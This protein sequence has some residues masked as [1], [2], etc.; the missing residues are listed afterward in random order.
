MARFVFVTV[1]PDGAGDD[2][3]AEGKGET[4]Y[5]NADAVKYVKP[6]SA[7]VST[8]V[9][10]DGVHAVNV[11]GTVH[12]VADRLGVTDRDGETGDA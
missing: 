4:R 9:F 7:N 8:L 1:I 12:E 2:A 5:V 6:R 10:G 3:A 11:A